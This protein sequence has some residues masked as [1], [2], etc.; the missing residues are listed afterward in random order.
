MSTTGA[1]KYTPEMLEAEIAR[2]KSLGGRPRKYTTEE[3]RK[4]ALN[5]ASLRVY[6]RKKYA[7]EG[8]EIPEEYTSRRKTYLTEED[9]KQARIQCSARHQMAHP[10]QQRIY[11]AVSH[12]RIHQLAQ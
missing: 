3:E 5:E 7:R 10:E 2:P 9:R 8:L 1:R 4:K 11:V 12:Y 6:W